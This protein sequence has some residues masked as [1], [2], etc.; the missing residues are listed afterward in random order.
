M[1]GTGRWTNDFLEARRA[2]G[3]PPADRVIETIFQAGDVDAVNGL[4]GN[5][6]RNEALIPEQLPVVVR[7]YLQATESLP[8][9]SD[10]AKIR[11][12]EEVFCEYG[13]HTVT[14]LLCASLPECYACGKGAEVLYLTN[15][16]SGQVHRRIFETAQFVLD[17][18]APGGLTPGAY[19]IRTTQKVR[20]MHAAIR[21]LARTNP[22]WRPEWGMPINQEDLAGTLMTFSV[23][24]IDG[25][26]KLNIPLAP[27]QQE[28]YLH[29][30]KNVGHILG[31]Q[32]DMLPENVEDARNL[33]EAIRQHQHLHSEAGVALTSALVDFMDSLVPHHA[34]DG[35]I[36]ALIW[37]LSGEEIAALLVVAR[38]D[39]E[40]ILLGPLRFAN[41]L[42]AR[43]DHR[44]ALVEKVAERVNLDLME[45]LVFVER[46]GTRPPFRIP[47][48]LCDRWN[49][50][51]AARAR[52]LSGQSAS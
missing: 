31:I 1:S 33:I 14:V 20:L 49:L 3:D 23:V 40:R 5:M 24:V 8:D 47:E 28:A 12:A 19:G 42:T 46:G 37:H 32:Q 51:P 38:P 50:S 25:L 34:L 4:L 6:V 16:L 45:G 26:K 48:T 17:V 18:M 30:W 21:Y 36:R 22:E 43:L 29:A 13:P 7:D 11:Q 39:W 41:A 15:R 52:T 35:L 27:E 10:T 44:V 9:W 2:L